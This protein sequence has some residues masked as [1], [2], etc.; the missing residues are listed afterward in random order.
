MLVGVVIV[1]W[2]LLFWLV[3]LPADTSSSPPTSTAVPSNA[4]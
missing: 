1:A 3:N 4:V 2:L